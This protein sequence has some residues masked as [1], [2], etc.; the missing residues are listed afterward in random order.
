[1]PRPTYTFDNDGHTVVAGDSAKL[2][3]EIN[4]ENARMQRVQDEFY[5]KRHIR[6]DRKEDQK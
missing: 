6:N 5:K 3:D 1:M 2:R 4:A